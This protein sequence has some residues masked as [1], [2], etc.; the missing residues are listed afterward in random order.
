MV[1]F[2]AFFMPW[3]ECSWVNMLSRACKNHLHRL[4]M[5]YHARGDKV[6]AKQTL[7]KSLE[8]NPNFPGAGEAKA[9]LNK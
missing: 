3:H 9:I 4:W 7:R 8:L 6:L 1:E 5:A 2:V